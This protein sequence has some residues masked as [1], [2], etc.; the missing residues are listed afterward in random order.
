[1]GPS[2]YVK[3]VGFKDVER[4]A[5]N[6]VF[7][8][9]MGRS[10]SYGLWTPEA[11]VAPSLVLI[12]LDS[13]EPALELTASEPNFGLT[14]IC[15]GHNA[16]QHAWLTF[17]RPLNWPDIVS[18]M[19]SLFVPL[20]Q[21]VTDFKLDLDDIDIRAFAPKAVKMSLLVEPSREDRLYLRA[22]LALAGLTK[23]DDALTG[24][25][26]LELTKKS[27]YDLVVVGL[28]VPDMDGWELIRQLM[29][30]EPAIGCVVVSSKD[31]SWHMSE[32]AEISGCQGLLAKPF[33]PIKIIELLRK[34]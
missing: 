5:L 29:T 21:S 2:V 8:L 11:P 12:D 6:T 20:A 1:M 23:V 22:R 18:A 17:E 31:T 4:H 15:I 28:D 14:M 3:V 24:A 13:Y 27:H 19:D 33:E 34:I 9:S 16:P 32:H 7:R 25:Q 26:A 30:L 10:V